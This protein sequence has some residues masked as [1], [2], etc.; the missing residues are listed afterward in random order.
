MS[1]Q[2]DVDAELRFHLEER[3]EELV[4]QGV[5][6]RD[7]R[8]RAI[9]EFGDVDRTRH[10]L[11]DI[12]RRM[13]R[14]RDRTEIFDA[15]RQDLRYV[16]RSLRRAP[17]L[18]LT[19]ILTL[20]LGIGVNTAMFS[21][22]DVIYL[23]PPAGVA[24]PEQFRRLWREVAVGEGRE[25]YDGVD[26]RGYAAV[27]RAAGGDADVI[28][29]SQP[30]R[31]RTA[32]GEIAPTVGV[33]GAPANYFDV[34]GL[35]PAIGRFYSAEEDGLASPANVAVISHDYWQ[36]EFDGDPGVLG[37]KLLLGIDQFTII[38]VGPRG[39]RGLDIAAAD[40]WAPVPALIRHYHPTSLPW[41]Q[42]PNVNGFVAIL[43][44]R[45][46]ANEVGL[47]NRATAVLRGPDVGYYQDTLTVA[48]LGPI[49][50]A[51]GAGELPSTTVVATR[52]AAVA[53]I[54]LLIAC[55]NVVNLLLARAMSRRREVAVRLALGISRGRLVRL[56]MT[57]GI[58]LA[59]AAAV[60][61]VIAANW[62]A[63]GLRSLLMPGVEWAAPTLHWRV[64]A[65]ALAVAIIAGVAAGLAPA[66]QSSRTDLNEA[67]KYGRRAG[68]P[69]QRLRS[70]LVVAQAALSVVL[71][72]G[73]LLFIRSLR[74]VRAHDVG[75]S[76]DRLLFAGVSY[77]TPDSARDA[78]LSARLRALEA[79]IAA[80]PGVEGVAFAHI[81][82][83]NGFGIT[84]FYPDADTIAHRKPEGFY[85][86]VTPSYFSTSGMP[87]LAG[88]T[89]ADGSRGR[90]TMIVNDAFANALW[91]GESAI[92]HCIRLTPTGDCMPI[93]GVVRT[94]INISITEPPSPHL[95]LSLDNPGRSALSASSIIVRA[96]PARLDGVQ[97][98]LR[99]IMR[100]EFAGGDLALTRMS[101]VMQ[102]QYRSWSLGAILFTLL[103]VLAL[104]VA[105]VGIY[106]SVSYSV[107]QRTH[108][109]GVR[110][111]LGAARG[112]VLRLVVGEG[113]RMVLVGI[114]L[115][116][117][118]AI[119][120][121][122]FI[123]SLLY[124]V[125]PSDPVS[126]LIVA[127][128]LASVAF[129]AAIVPAGRAANADPVSALRAE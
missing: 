6:P 41:W 66:L 113:V 121:G 15:L 32:R 3:I 73:A 47:A 23:R 28:Y 35:K 120:A 112:N 71:L 126:M 115:G 67:L 76:I 70:V 101:E 49:S 128:V 31:M 57:E 38:G 26:Y 125:K 16:A 117:V 127:A 109:F 56:L 39:F 84:A 74:N 64:L 124:A 11:R 10:S 102:P 98:T 90:P 4:A 94:A 8:A 43:R 58:A 24:H 61:A 62:A 79:R 21:L 19:I 45:D 7:A 13:A 14:R 60:A 42:D 48:R 77:D 30:R 75:Y 5:D 107:T 122:R 85:T 33:I 72:V 119:A 129:V 123:A 36:R 99:E 59:I 86:A 22:L 111:A 96:D 78:S 46:G 34:L 18:S 114:V 54:V 95:Y 52:I 82:P 116:A 105:G 37:K 12:D 91:P 69:R 81:R 25:F 9:D 2:R 88:H 27:R 106:S 100:A 51:R 29:Y 97:R 104:I 89:F 108:E 40:V 63:S 87:L 103:G 65:F 1:I 53:V 68:R 92:G 80:I 44:L 93:I 118:L 55:A 83:K 110:L 50:E 17:A 20:S